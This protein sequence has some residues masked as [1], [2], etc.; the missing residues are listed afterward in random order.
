MDATKQKQKPPVSV[1]LPDDLQAFLLKEA[2]TGWRSL[3]REIIK[4]LE[5]S[6][7]RQE[8]GEVTQ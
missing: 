5:E 7:Q 3:S 6:R 4:R 8:A 2:E 1:R